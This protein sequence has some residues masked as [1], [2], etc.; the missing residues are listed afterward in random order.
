MD[1]CRVVLEVYEAFE[2]KLRTSI[3]GEWAILARLKTVMPVKVALQRIFT[4]EDVLSFEQG[5]RSVAN[6]V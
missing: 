3:V 2:P 4:T 5:Q 6:I 1:T